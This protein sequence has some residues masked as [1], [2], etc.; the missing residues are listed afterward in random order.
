MRSVHLF[1]RSLSA[2]S[3]VAVVLLGSTALLLSRPALARTYERCDAD[4][5]H[6]VRIKC[7]RDGDRCWKESEYARNRLYEHPGRWVCDADHDRCHYE[8][9]GHKWSPRHWDHDDE[10]RGDR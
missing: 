4:G 3:G 6:C 5:D 9:R 10:D 2:M 8:Y 1:R 7:D